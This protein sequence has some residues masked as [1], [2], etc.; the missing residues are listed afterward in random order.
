MDNTIILILVAA[1]MFA[2]IGGITL[3][4]ALIEPIQYHL[5]V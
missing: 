5:S 3:I 4:I 2:I 1:G